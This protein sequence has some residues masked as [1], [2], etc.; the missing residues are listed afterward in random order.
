VYLAG[1]DSPLYQFVECWY[2]YTISATKE[3]RHLHNTSSKSKQNQ[4]IEHKTSTSD[5]KTI[6]GLHQIESKAYTLVQVTPHKG[7]TLVRQ[8]SRLTIVWSR[9]SY[10]TTKTIE[11][12]MLE[13]MSLWSLAAG[14]TR[15]RSPWWHDDELENFTKEIRRGEMGG[16]RERER[17]W[18]RRHRCE[19]E[20]SWLSEGYN[21]AFL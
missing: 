13:T 20:T 7:H 4:R 15:S 11:V 6:L 8:A 2:S 1:S 18:W 12:Q 21:V 10:I 14:M 16:V 9:L 3:S 17:E 5:K 19:M